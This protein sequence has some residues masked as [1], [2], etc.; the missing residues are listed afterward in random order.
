MPLTDSIQLLDGL[1]AQTPPI[2]TMLDTARELLAAAAKAGAAPAP[3]VHVRTLP[4]STSM[5]SRSCATSGSS[6]QR[7]RL[8]FSFCRWT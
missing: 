2:Q 8:R 6:A 3:R 7:A 1:T 5:C 4:A